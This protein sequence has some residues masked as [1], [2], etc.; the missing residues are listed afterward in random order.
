MKDK[1][2]SKLNYKLLI[3]I[4]VIIPIVLSVSYAYFLAKVSGDSTVVDGTA[5]SKF[6]IDLVTSNDGY[7]NA[8]DML[9]ITEASSAEKAAKGTF[10][11]KTGGNDY[12]INYSLS[13]TNI[14]ISDN[15][16]ASDDLKWELWSTDNNTKLSSGTFKNATT[17]LTLKD[18][19]VIDSN[20]VNNYEL[21]IYLL[22]TNTNQ[23]SLLNGTLSV[24]VT[25]NAE[26]INTPSGA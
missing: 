2:E 1:K 12:K 11:V 5:T 25:M 26:M 13:L 17:S 10:A 18:N 3:M 7:I 23:I 8:T 19:I 9:P 6:N 16:K 21:R 4:A 15:I 24:K 14:E 20:S 22:E